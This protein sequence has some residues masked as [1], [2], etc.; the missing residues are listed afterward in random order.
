MSGSAK[1]LIHLLNYEQR[2]N[3]VFFLILL[4]FSTIFEGLSIA[5]VFPL[6][7]M[8]LDP[9]YLNYLNGKIPFLEIG[10]LNNE[11]IIVF[12]LILIT[13]VYFFCTILYLLY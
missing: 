10:N 1:K 8:I 6:I 2:K 9:S 3:S 11:E 7:K 13:S 12:T 4:F 5:L